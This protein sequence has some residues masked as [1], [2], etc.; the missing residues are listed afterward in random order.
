MV[1][2]GMTSSAL[3]NRIF[4]TFLDTPSVS[5]MK[6]LKYANQ[7]GVPI[8]TIDS[9]NIGQLLP[10]I[11]VS[12]EIKM[13][14]Q[15]AINAGKKVVISQTEL[16]Y[17]EWSGVGYVIL[18]PLTGAGAYRISG[19]L[20]G[21]RTAKILTKPPITLSKDSMEYQRLKEAFLNAVIKKAESLIGTPYRWGG[22]DPKTG[23][24]CSGFTQ[25]VYKQA[26][27]EIP[28]TAPS[29]YDFFKN[30]GMIFQTPQSGDLFF[31]KNRDGNIYH[32]GIL[33]GIS[34]DGKIS[35]I[36]APGEGRPVQ[37]RSDLINSPFWKSNIAGYGRPI[38]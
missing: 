17:Y 25:Y 15:N 1:I 11:Q 23:F 16:Q 24:D 4:E 9:T 7:Q 27:Y 31:W 30:N 18:D 36:D 13:E 29:Q 10:A 35:F 20:D 34:Q 22:T 38:E 12:S 14:I 21:G 8:Y 3:E 33:K 37:E 6:L 28:R 5:A 32:T 2:S 26:G 19:G